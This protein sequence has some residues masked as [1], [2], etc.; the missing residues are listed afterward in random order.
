MPN[1]DGD[2]ILQVSPPQVVVYRS[3]LDVILVAG[4]IFFAFYKAFRIVKGTRLGWALGIYNFCIGVLFLLG[5]FVLPAVDLPTHVEEGIMT[6][7]RALVLASIIW[8]VYEVEL[9][10]GEMI[11]VRND[12]RQRRG[13]GHQ[14]Y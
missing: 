10:R 4:F 5:I 8:S 11:G 9:T 3:W 2:L 14:G 6:V 7:G 12:M 13:Q 1:M